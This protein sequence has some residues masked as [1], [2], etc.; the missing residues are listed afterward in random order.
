MQ[1]N[2]PCA[3][4]KMPK[5]GPEAVQQKF[6]FLFQNFAGSVDILSCNQR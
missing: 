5:V 2:P 1:L 4:V 6:G 3:H